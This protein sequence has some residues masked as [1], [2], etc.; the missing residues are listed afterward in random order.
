MVE[1]GG[2]HTMT[3]ANKHRERSRRS[4]G[5]TKSTIGSLERSNYYSRESKSMSAEKAMSVFAKIGD[6]L[7][8][9][10]SRL[11]ERFSQNFRK[12]DRG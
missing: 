9:L 6:R 2:L 10:A 4:Y 1:K 7:K 12:Q 8:N 5:I 3:S 11:T